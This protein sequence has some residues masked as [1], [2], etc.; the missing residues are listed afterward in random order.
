MRTYQC[1]TYAPLFSCSSFQ[2]HRRSRTTRPAHYVLSV[3]AW[4]EKTE[5]FSAF[6]LAQ[7]RARERNC[8]QHIESSFRVPPS[9]STAEKKYLARVRETE[10][11]SSWNHISTFSDEVRPEKT[12]KVLSIWHTQGSAPRSSYLPCQKL[13]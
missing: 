4:G 3:W 1:R 10:N 13:A 9:R 7:G 2:E 8:V 11:S 5:F 12:R 6:L